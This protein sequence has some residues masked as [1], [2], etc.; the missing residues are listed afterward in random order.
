M[1]TNGDDSKLSRTP[2]EPTKRSRSAVKLEIAVVGAGLSGLA[3]ARLLSEAGSRVRVFDKARGPGGRMATRRRGV[4]RFDHGA[5]YFTV[6]DPNFRRALKEWQADGLVARWL[7]TLAVVQNGEIALKD[8]S[9]ERWVG[10][11]GMSA[12]CGHLANGLD[13]TYGSR[14]VHLE[15]CDNRWRLET[16]DGADAGRFDAV[17]LSAP[18]PQTAALLAAP[19]PE[20]AAR[21][22]EVEMAPC[23]AVMASYPHDLELGFDGAFVDDSPL[24]WVARNGSKPGRPSGETWVLHASPEWSREHLELDQEVAAQWLVDA[25]CEAVGR[26]HPQPTSLTAHRWR[27]AL[28]VNPLT[29]PCLIDPERALA[30]CGDWAGGPRV[31]GAFLSGC[32]AARRLIELRSMTKRL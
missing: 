10:V 4:L 7:G 12:I 17:V 13:V 27:F 26:K 8:D 19:A 2:V 31:E 25:F 32:A 15:H 20:L 21:A 22:G 16:A 1:M 30:A 11:P 14:I 3:C 28:P 23:W 29:E 9:T 5:Q 6:R 18:A 24:A